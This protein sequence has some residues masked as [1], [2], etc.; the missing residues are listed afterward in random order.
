MHVESEQELHYE[1]K[2]TAFEKNE[3][4]TTPTLSGYDFCPFGHL[5]GWL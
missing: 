4:P 3:L 2:N 5:F 1:S